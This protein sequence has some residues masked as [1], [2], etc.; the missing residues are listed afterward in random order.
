[1]PGVSRRTLDPHTLLAP[2]LEFRRVALA[3]SGGA[4]SLALMLLAHALTEADGGRDRFVVY[5]VNHGLRPEAVEEVAFVAREAERLGFRVRVLTWDGDKPGSG[6]QE[7]ARLARYRLFG[8]AMRLDEAEAV[9][10]AHHIEDQAET[11]LMRLAHGSGIEGLRGMDVHAK[12]HGVTVLRPLLW[13]DPADL[14][15]LVAAAGL[16]PVIDPSNA[17]VDYE[18]VRWRRMLPPLAELGLDANRLARFAGRM[19]D[20]DAALGA[21]TREALASVTFGSDGSEASFARDFLAE[22]P[23]TIAARLVG[24]VLERVG[25]GRKPHALAA[26]EELADRLVRERLTAT[27]HGCIVRGTGRT[28]R[29]VREKAR[30][31]TRASQKSEPSLT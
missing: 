18:R 14:R 19:R 30:R 17:D 24:R 21:M 6:V 1:M 4:D 31:P 25:G 2:T 20:A 29:I 11:I 23:R 8:D 15:A 10:T 7:A 27:L 28:I 3:V 16:T 13:I 12:V 9:V 5:T 22:L 26:V